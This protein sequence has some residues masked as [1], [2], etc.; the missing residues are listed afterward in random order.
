MASRLEQVLEQHPGKV[1]L[2]FKNYPLRSH[3]M[4][5]KAAVAAMAA[6]LRGKFWDFHDRVFQNHNRLSDSVLA[7]IRKELG[8]VDPAF[9]GLLKNPEIAG[10]I[11]RDVQEGR[12]AGVRGTPTIFV[13]GKRHPGPY[14]PE[15]FREAIEAELK[16]SGHASGPRQRL[17][18]A[19][20]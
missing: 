13:N 5:Y 3:S 20:H 16:R 10:L 14:T 4:A 12:L 1:R 11:Q 19:G 2:V 7:Q 18:A 15:G 8:L 17:S 9:E 6:D